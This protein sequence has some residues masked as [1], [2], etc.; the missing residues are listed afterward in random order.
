[1]NFIKAAN[2]QTC[3][4]LLIEFQNEW[5]SS[6]GKLYPLFEDKQQVVN[7]IKNA[8]QVLAATRLKAMPVIHSGL[9]YSYKHQ[10]LGDIHQGVFSAIKSKQTF[11]VNEVGSQFAEPFAPKPGEF[12]VSGRVGTSAFTGSNLD[13]YLRNNRIHKLFIM[14]Y[15]LHVCVESTLRAA[16]DLG[17]ETIVI[18]DA[19][20]CFTFEQRD[21]VLKNVIHHFGVSMKTQDYIKQLNYEVITYENNG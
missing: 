21:Y 3:A 10:E 14:G 8:S 19:C 18:E 7:S 1:M 5:L 17:Y 2:N 13:N 9:A 16:H 11:L 6:Q 12:I 15:A 4:L 20:A